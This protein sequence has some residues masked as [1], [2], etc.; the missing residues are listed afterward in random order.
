[1]ADGDG[2]TA[3]PPTVEE[4]RSWAGHRLDG[5]SGATVGRIEGPGRDGEAGWL[6][7]RMGRF[8]HH[9]LVPAR[10]AVAAAG[11]VWVPYSREQIR[12]AP[13]VE[14]SEALTPEREAD[15]VAYYGIVD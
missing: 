2:A 7:C 8:G 14:P 12:R 3:A 13:R 6:L 4:I 15:L 1:M 11:H 5:L 10:D 9:C